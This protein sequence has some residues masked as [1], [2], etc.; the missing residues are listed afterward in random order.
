MT[1]TPPRGTRASINAAASPS[2][3]L[4]AAV[5]LATGPIFLV[6]RDVYGTV[7][8]H[9]WLGVFGVAQAMRASGTLDTLAAPRAPLLVIGALSVAVLVA[10]HRLWIRPRA[11]SAPGGQRA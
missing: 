6:S 1:P 7:A 11:A 4:L 10:A 8:F 9:N 3:A 5:G 2:V